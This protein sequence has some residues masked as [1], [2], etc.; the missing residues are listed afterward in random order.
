MSWWRSSVEPARFLLCLFE[1]LSLSLLCIWCFGVRRSVLELGSLVQLEDERNAFLNAKNDEILE[2]FIYYFRSKRE[3]T[4]LVSG[5]D[6]LVVHPIG[7]DSQDSLRAPHF[8]HE[9][10]FQEAYKCVFECVRAC[11][12]V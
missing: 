10:G 11:T 3:G 12:Q 7:K 1:K 5:P 9:L 6:H 4:S 8:A 2:I